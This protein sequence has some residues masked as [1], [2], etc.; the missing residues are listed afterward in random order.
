MDPMVP[1]NVPQGVPTSGIALS[2]C[3][4]GHIYRLAS[5]NLPYGIFLQNRASFLGIRVKLGRAYLDEE[6]HGDTGA[7]H[8]TAWPLE[9]VGEVPSGLF[10]GDYLVEADEGQAL[11][12]WLAA[13][14]RAHGSVEGYGPRGQVTG[15]GPVGRWGGAR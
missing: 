13:F 15:E 12:D 4:P 8:G 14:E 2:D 10:P 9:E 6:D 5:R 1:K 11:W 7:P 3:R